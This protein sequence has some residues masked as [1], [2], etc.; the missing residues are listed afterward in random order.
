[1]DKYKKILKLLKQG[2]TL[3]VYVKDLDYPNEYSRIR[4][5]HGGMSEYQFVL[6]NDQRQFVPSCFANGVKYPAQQTPEQLVSTMQ[7]YD[8]NNRL[9]VK[10]V[11]VI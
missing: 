1:M 3:Q 7:Y 5:L 4:I 10:H 2:K 11:V 6:L 8:Q 9:K